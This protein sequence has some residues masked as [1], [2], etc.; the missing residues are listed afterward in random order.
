MSWRTVWWHAIWETIHDDRV[1]TL[2]GFGYGFPLG[3]LVPYMKNSDTRTPHNIFYY[4]L[5]YTGWLG[6]TAFEVYNATGQS[7]GITM[8]AAGITSATF[9]NYLETPFQA[10]PF[11]LLAGLA[12]APVLKRYRR[13]S[14][15]C[16]SGTQLL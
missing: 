8:W 5:G 4:T 13:V 16:T 7:Y 6:V 14:H 11:Y 15:A 1:R 10:I 3:D 12:A 9:S 2:I